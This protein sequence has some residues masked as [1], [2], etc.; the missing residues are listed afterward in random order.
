MRFILA[1]VVSLLT[2]LSYADQWY[3]VDEATWLISPSAHARYIQVNQAVIHGQHCAAIINAHGDFAQLEQMIN[4]VKN[5]LTVPV[6]YLFSTSAE[7]Q[8]IQGMALLQRAFPSAKWYTNDKVV[9][10]FTRYQQGL[11]AKLSMLAQS[12]SISKQRANKLSDT[13]QN[14][15]QAHLEIAQQRLSDWRTLQLTPPIA[16]KQSLS[17]D[18]GDYPLTLTA[19][20]AYSQGDMFIFS[21]TNGALFAGNTVDE[22][23]YVTHHQLAPWLASLQTFNQDNTIKWL[24]PAHGKPYKRVA[25][26]R[27]ITFIQALLNN[28][29]ATEFIN[30][31]TAL[32]KIDEATQTRMA[33]YYQLAQRRLATTTE[34]DPNAVL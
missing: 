22:L 9:K 5:K 25:L 27:P 24:L 14:Q 23:P 34:S 26:A 30:K 17:L 20:S 6:C 3:K 12:L 4:S 31:V 32:Y 33:H 8:Q 15:W 18:L 2:N 16:I 13:E 29:P 28:V 21:Q 19:S 10:G 7:Q 11:I 1:V